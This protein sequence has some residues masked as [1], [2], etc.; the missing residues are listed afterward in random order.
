MRGKLRRLSNAA[1]RRRSGGS[2][3]Y[4]HISYWG[5][6]HDYLWLEST[7]PAQVWREMTITEQFARSM[8]LDDAMTRRLPSGAW[9][10]K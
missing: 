10:R 9:T 6:P 3:I 4:Y 7:A 8:S 1:E 2:G 5:R